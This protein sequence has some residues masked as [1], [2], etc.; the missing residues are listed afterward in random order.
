[1]QIN[2][3]DKFVANGYVYVPDNINAENLIQFSCDNIDVLESTHDGKNTFHCTQM[4]AWQRSSD[5]IM[6]G[7]PAQ[8]SNRSAKIDHK[9]LTRFHELDKAIHPSNARPSPHFQNGTEYEMERWLNEKTH[10]CLS[11]N[12]NL[13]WAIARQFGS[14]DQKVPVWGG[15]NEARCSVDPPITTA[16]MLPILQAPADSNDTMASVIN[17]FVSI[18]RH[19]GQQYTVITA[20]L[21]L[22]SRGKELV[23]ANK[24]NYG[25]VIFRMGGLHVC[26][27]FLKAIGQ[28]IESAGLDYVWIESAV[29]APNTTETVLEGKAY[30]RAVRGH[31][32]AYESLWRIRWRMFR[33]WLAKYH[34]KAL[35]C[36][37]SV[38][39]PVVELFKSAEKPARESFQTTVG[40]LEGYIQSQN[41]AELL[42]EYDGS[43]F[44]SK[45]YTFWLSYMKMV[46]TLL[47][48]IRTE[49][50]GNWEL[51]LESFAAILPW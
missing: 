34:E 18:S 45:N 42:S 49:R 16:A 2:V 51:H 48:F 47:N 24:E 1:M 19:F 41:L 11:A 8:Q 9:V 31:M 7:T 4:M 46:E 40:T 32:L 22:Y 50:E 39:S 37:E 43:M 44:S 3:L 17:R 14:D 6:T 5:T 21:P 38:A 23:W 12:T 25:N 29:F 28:H 33:D 13:A 15:F 35:E 30:Y 27:N 20:D 26:I 10:T 36:L